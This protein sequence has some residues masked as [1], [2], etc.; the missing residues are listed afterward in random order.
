MDLNWSEIRMES[1]LE[2]LCEVY[3]KVEVESGWQSKVGN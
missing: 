2:V 3:L 1:E